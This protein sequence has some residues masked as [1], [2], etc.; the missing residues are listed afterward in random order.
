VGD[1]NQDG[2]LDLIFGNFSLLKPIVKS[3][4][5]WKKGPPFM[6]LTNKGVRK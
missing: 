3:E 6:V 2:Y 5:D 4:R 1:Y